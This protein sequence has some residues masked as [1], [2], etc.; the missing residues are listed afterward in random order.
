LWLQ[1]MYC[2][3]VFADAL[4]MRGMEDSFYKKIHHKMSVYR[5]KRVYWVSSIAFLNDSEYEAF[6][7]GMRLL[8]LQRHFKRYLTP[9]SM[10]LNLQTYMALLR[11]TWLSEND[12]FSI[13]AAERSANDLCSLG[14]DALAQAKEIKAAELLVR[15]SFFTEAAHIELHDH[16]KSCL[17]RQIAR[18]SSFRKKVHDVVNG[19]C[20]KAARLYICNSKRFRECVLPNMD[21]LFDGD[22]YDSDG[23]FTA[24]TAIL[25]MRFCGRGRQCGDA[26]TEKPF[27]I[28]DEAFAALQ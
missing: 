17:I 19:L 9:Y 27:W 18:Q 25:R 8:R 13:W 3:F 14:M 11:V 21:I 6:Y 10:F 24:A 12:L 22:I 26:V 2:A 15:V 20:L 4:L 28:T 5:T 23:A 1:H 16:V 7:C